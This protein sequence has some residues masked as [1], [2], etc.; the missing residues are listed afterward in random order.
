[1]N[2]PVIYIL[3]LLFLYASCD[4]DKKG[5]GA[6]SFGEIPED[7]LFGDSQGELMIDPSA[8]ED[9]ISNISSPVEM[10][11]LLKATGVPFS[12]KYLCQTDNYEEYNT[13][14]KKALN[15]GV[16]GAD[17][18]YLN[19]YN[20]TGTVISN[21]KAIKDLADDL[22]IGHF[23]DFSTIKRLATNSEN[24]D[25]LSYISVSS[26][27]NM[28]EYLRD[29][30][31]SNISSLI[32]TG[33]WLEAMYIAT[34][35]IK[36]APDNPEVEERIGEQKLI[37]NDL[38]LI[39]KNYRK[40]KRFYSLIEDIESIKDAFK[41]VSITYI[42]GEPQTKEVNGMLMIV[43]TSTSQVD[44][45]EATLEEII[46]VVEKVRNKLIAI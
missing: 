42:P 1:M 23:F 21:L 5:G 16:F 9:I 41:G 26:F 38:I 10:A 11:A 6:S 32:I 22:S 18:G 37:L 13:N 12:Q 7:S 17:L 24:L 8:M 40:N 46:S 43:Q 28:D 30:N 2:R 29:N 25:S 4:S 35:V 15:L 27:N 36:E 34:Q 45:P 19:M 3:I 14:F 39:L 44:V 31:R 20:K 33:V